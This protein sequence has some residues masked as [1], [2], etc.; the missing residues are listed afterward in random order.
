D[1]ITG[2][3]LQLD[4]NPAA[5]AQVALLGQG[6]RVTM[7]EPAKFLVLIH[8]GLHM[9]RTSTDGSFH[10]SPEPGAERLAIVHETGWAIVPIPSPPSDQISL[11]PWARVEGILRIGTGV[12][13]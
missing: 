6:L 7:Q 10:L 11:A 1:D 4:S 2:T 13:A 12:G 8:S 9:T 3:V 5:G